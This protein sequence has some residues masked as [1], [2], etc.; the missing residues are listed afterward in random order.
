MGIRRSLQL[1][2]AFDLIFSFI[3][4]HS[5]YPFYGKVSFYRVKFTNG[6]PIKEGL[7]SSFFFT[8]CTEYSLVLGL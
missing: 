1:L 3:S 5:K 6:V 4:L 8:P 7:I 2:L